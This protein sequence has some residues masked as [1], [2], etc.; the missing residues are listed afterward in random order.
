ME[1]IAGEFSIVYFQGSAGPLAASPSSLD[2]HV[3]PR[4]RKK[5]PDGLKKTRSSSGKKKRGHR[6]V[7]RDPGSWVD[8]EYHAHLRALLTAGTLNPSLALA[9]YLE[10]CNRNGVAPTY[11]LRSHVGHYLKNK[12]TLLRDSD[13]FMALLGPGDPIDHYFIMDSLQFDHSLTDQYEWLSVV[14]SYGWALKKLS[15][16]MNKVHEQ[17]LKKFPHGP[18]HRKNTMK[19]FWENWKYQATAGDLN[20]RVVGVLRSR[21]GCSGIAEVDEYLRMCALRNYCLVSKRFV[22]MAKKNKKAASERKKFDVTSRWEDLCCTI[23]NLKAA[24]AAEK[25]E[26]RRLEME[27]EGVR[28]ALKH[29]E[30]IARLL[31]EKE[32]PDADFFNHRR[33]TWRKSGESLA[34]MEKRL[35]DFS[36]AKLQGKVSHNS[37]QPLRNADSDIPP[38]NVVKAHIK[39]LK[40]LMKSEL[41]L[42]VD[43][44]VDIESKEKHAIVP[45]KAHLHL[46]ALDYYFT[47]QREGKPP[48]ECLHI[49]IG[50]W[51]H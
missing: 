27:V 23:D 22:T 16:D 4:K 18:L 43:A 51:I 45:L 31:E 14:S 24:L 37:Y 25:Q 44:G 12:R 36:L 28:E 15:N 7:F 21:P 8:V 50:R 17:Y 32:N 30:D 41:A 34:T 49:K 20:A 19:V 10:W 1:P 47:L 33:M 26:R 35:H 6:S 13:S 5:A 11:T 3:T 40:A 29:M 38:L 2:H 42:H 48:P 46:V 9:S 39:H